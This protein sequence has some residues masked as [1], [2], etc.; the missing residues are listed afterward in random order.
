VG[1]IKKACIGDSLAIVVDEYFADPGAYG[2]EEAW[3]ATLFWAAHV[4]CDFSGY[5]DM[6]LG[7]A[8]LLGYTLPKAF[9]APLL[10]P[11]V[12]DFWRRWHITLSRFLHE[13]LYVP[14]GGNRGAW[15]RVYR[16]LMITMLLAGLWHGAGW[17][18][19]LWG[20]LHGVALVLERIT[21]WRP[22]RVIGTQLTFYFFCVS[23][24]VFRV[25]TVKDG[26]AA[27][28]AFVLFTPHSD[29]SPWP[30]LGWFGVLAL[31]HG[32][33]RLRPVERWFRGL[34]GWAFGLLWGAALAV[35][36]AFVPLGYRPFIY[37]QF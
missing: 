28:R 22:P 17:N 32:A 6:A 20:G 18:F 13:Y 7:S 29:A 25:H 36:L 19:V 3:P 14:L 12:T 9:D 5:T 24:I 8:A 2:A 21:R 1:F 4:Y 33:C 31:V 27:L 37:F 26:V 10:A 30:W 35:V 15:W 34:P 23:L 16:N 11:T